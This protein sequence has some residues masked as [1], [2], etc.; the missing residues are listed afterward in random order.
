[1]KGQQWEQKGRKV[2]QFL[3]RAEDPDD[4][5]RAARGTAAGTLRPAAVSSLRRPTALNKQPSKA[6]PA[7]SA[8]PGASGQPCKP[9]S[10]PQSALQRIHQRV[11]DA[12]ARARGHALPSKQAAAGPAMAPTRAAQGTARPAGG[13]GRADARLAPG[14]AAAKSVPRAPAFNGKAE[15][16]G[17]AS[18]RPGRGPAAPRRGG[19]CSCTLLCAR[20]TCKGASSGRQGQERQSRSSAGRCSKQGARSPPGQA[21]PCTALSGQGACLS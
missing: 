21:R 13:A 14:A 7:S 5:R 11:S 19:P 20:C 4:A 6:T 16:S 12:A 8:V 2:A 18:T 1:M 10:A 9:G 3:Q 17:A 15:A